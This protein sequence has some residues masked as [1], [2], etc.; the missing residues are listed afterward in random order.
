LP[1]DSISFAALALTLARPFLNRKGK[2]VLETTALTTALQGFKLFHYRGALFYRISSASPAQPEKLHQVEASLSQ[3]Q[4][5][6]ETA[7]ALK[8]GRQLPLRQLRSIAKRDDLFPDT[9]ILAGMN[10]LV[11]AR[12]LRA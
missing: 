3:F 5:A 6:N 10:G 12:M 2:C 8:L 1:L 7:F 11:H 4:A 9:L